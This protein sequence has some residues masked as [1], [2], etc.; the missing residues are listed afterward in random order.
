MPPNVSQLV[1]IPG[2]PGVLMELAAKSPGFLGV[3]IARTI[4]LQINPLSQTTS[5]KERYV[6][7]Q[8]WNITVDPKCFVSGTF[9]F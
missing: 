9:V 4:S 5:K 2:M 3:D 8:F 6:E 1:G 7:N